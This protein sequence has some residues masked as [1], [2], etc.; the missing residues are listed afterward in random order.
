VATL[1]KYLSHQVKRKAFSKTHQFE[2]AVANITIRIEIQRMQWF[3][4]PCVCESLCICPDLTTPN[5]PLVRDLREIRGMKGSPR[6]TSGFSER[7]NMI[8]EAKARRSKD[9]SYC[10]HLRDWHAPSHEIITSDKVLGLCT[11][12]YGVHARNQE[13]ACRGPSIFLDGI[14]D[15]RCNIGK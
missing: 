13:T 7:S 6:L 8:K 4:P 1:R 3:L 9:L 12:R 10:L 11:Y 2:L 15:Y 14:F 5:S